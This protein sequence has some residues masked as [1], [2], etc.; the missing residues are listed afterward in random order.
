MPKGD[1]TIMGF[2]RNSCK[3]LA[4]R[5]DKQYNV[6]NKFDIK[7]HENESWIKKNTAQI[8]NKDLINHTLDKLMRPFV[9]SLQF[10]SK[11]TNT[12][13]PIELPTLLHFYHQC[14]EFSTILYNKV[15]YALAPEL[16][17]C[18]RLLLRVVNG[19]SI[20]IWPHCDYLHLDGSIYQCI[21]ESQ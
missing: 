16:C 8:L 15:V 3:K 20:I 11:F 14:L 1:V 4:C 9:L 7:W 17:I 18:C 10:L 2:Q 19:N 6:I 13:L 5:K 12:I 21:W